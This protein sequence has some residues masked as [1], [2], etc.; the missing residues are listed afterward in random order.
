MPDFG[1]IT[2]FRVRRV[3]GSWAKPRSIKPAK[4]KSSLLSSQADYVPV[5]VK[6]KTKTRKEESQ[7]SSETQGCEIIWTQVQQKSFEQ[8]IK[9]FP[10]G[11]PERWER[12]A[13]KVQGKSTEECIQRFKFL[14]EKVKAKRVEN[15]AS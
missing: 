1:A 6:A 13:G 2:G 14:A 15:Q 8:A 11:T 12:I 9:Q 5:E 4:F 7:E 10:K 3:P